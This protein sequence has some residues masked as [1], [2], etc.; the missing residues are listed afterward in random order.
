MRL[1]RNLMTQSQPHREGYTEAT[2]GASARP[3]Q[4]SPDPRAYRDLNTFLSDYRL[5]R[6]P[7]AGGIMSETLPPP[8]RDKS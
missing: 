1:E 7:Q 5:D 6:E 3:G 2:S 4:L 8:Y